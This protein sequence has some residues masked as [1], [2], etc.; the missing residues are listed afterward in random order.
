MTVVARQ[1]RVLRGKIRAQVQ[2]QI[3]LGRRIIRAYQENPNLLIFT[4]TTGPGSY[5]DFGLCLNQ[6]TVA[7]AALTPST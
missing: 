7:L 4:G 2:Y 6:M 5:T 1:R 3:T